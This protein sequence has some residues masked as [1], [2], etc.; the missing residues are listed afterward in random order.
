[1]SEYRSKEQDIE[2]AKQLEGILS[3]GSEDQ[4]GH[5]IIKCIYILL[6]AKIDKDEY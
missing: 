2:F 3:E 5:M 4:P 1:M 6:R